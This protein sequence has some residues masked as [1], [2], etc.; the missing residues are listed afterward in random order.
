MYREL[1]KAPMDAQLLDA[2]GDCTNKGWSL[3]RGRFQP[4]KERLAERSSV[5][6][7]ADRK[8]EAWFNL[9]NRA[10]PIYVH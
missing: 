3:G 2:I 8:G 1:V 9:F 7:K 5:C 6:R 10:S 4:K